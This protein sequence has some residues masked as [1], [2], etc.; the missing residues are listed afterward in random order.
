MAKA[1]PIHSQL[2]AH[3]ERNTSRTEVFNLGSVSNSYEDKS[4]NSARSGELSCGDYGNID[5]ECNKDPEHEFSGYESQ[6]SS[7][8]D[9]FDHLREQVNDI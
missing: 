2:G 3:H 8:K 6:R 1:L 5:I 9:I 7:F 4:G